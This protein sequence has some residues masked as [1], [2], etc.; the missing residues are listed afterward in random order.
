M[1]EVSKEINRYAPGA[2]VS[3]DGIVLA[4]WLVSK[5]EA[6]RARQEGSRP[7]AELQE[8]AQ[9]LQG[10]GEMAAVGAAAESPGI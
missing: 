8:I 3:E 5:F 10:L 2:F 9:E 7:A 6:L 4:P 1:S